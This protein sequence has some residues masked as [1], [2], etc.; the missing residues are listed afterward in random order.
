MG[1][2]HSLIRVYTSLPGYPHFRIAQ[3]YLSGFY[4]TDREIKA[5]LRVHIIYIFIKGSRQLRVKPFLHDFTTGDA[6][7][8]DSFPV[9]HGSEVD[10]ES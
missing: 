3:P 9:D 5:T 8:I 10:A 2:L 7:L 6:S 4:Q 1:F